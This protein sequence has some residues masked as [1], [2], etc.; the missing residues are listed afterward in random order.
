MPIPWPVNAF[1]I[2]CCR[3]FSKGWY[4]HHLLSQCN[5]LDTNLGVNKSLINIEEGK[6]KIWA[7]KT[8][9]RGDAHL[10]NCIENLCKICT[11]EHKIGKTGTFF[12][13]IWESSLRFHVFLWQFKPISMRKIFR[14]KICLCKRINCILYSSHTIVLIRNCRSL[15]GFVVG[16]F[17]CLPEWREGSHLP[18]RARDCP[19]Q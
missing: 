6:G 4:G 7:S 15:I 8:W 18:C 9:R 17:E 5:T 1:N 3:L 11:F 2:Q 16:F 19:V 10:R 14:Q 12:C 13:T